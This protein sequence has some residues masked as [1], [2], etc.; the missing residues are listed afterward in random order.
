[1]RFRCARRNETVGKR[2]IYSNLVDGEATI[3]HNGHDWNATFKNSFK[4]AI[5][6]Q[7]LDQFDLIIQDVH[8][9]DA[10][11]YICREPINKSEVRAELRIIGKCALKFVH[12][13]FLYIFSSPGSMQFSQKVDNW[14]RILY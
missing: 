5:D 3:V 8:F 11:T 12:L 13:F 7:T 2:W 4:Y 6:N 10:G 14:K 9:S 1:M